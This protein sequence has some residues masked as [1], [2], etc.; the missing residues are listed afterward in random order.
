MCFRYLDFLSLLALA[1]SNPSFAW[2]RPD[3]YNFTVS[4]KMLKAKDATDVVLMNNFSADFPVEEVNR[5][6]LKP[7][8][9]LI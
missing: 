7:D 3:F 5:Y 4:R 2:L 1:S 9:D 6:K 8:P